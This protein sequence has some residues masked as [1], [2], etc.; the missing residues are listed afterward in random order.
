VRALLEDHLRSS[1]A[2]DPGTRLGFLFSFVRA[3][4]QMAAIAATEYVLAQI[5]AED[6]QAV[7]AA[8]KILH[9]LDGDMVGILDTLLP[10]IRSEQWPGCC[11]PWFEKTEAGV[12]SRRASAWVTVRTEMA[13]GNMSREFVEKQLPVLDVLATD[14]LAGLADLLPKAGPKDLAVLAIPGGSLDLQCV[15]ADSGKP[16]LLR[17]IRSSGG[18]WQARF[19]LVDPVTAREGTRQLDAD[20]WILAAASR[21]SQEFVSH[22]VQKPDGNLWKPAVRLPGKQTSAFQGRTEELAALRDW[23]NDVED[24]KV[25]LVYGDG[26][27]GKTTLALEFLNDL[28]DEPA[29]ITW[30]PDVITF[31][32]AKQTR[33]SPEGLV[34]LK[35]VEPAIL[36]G[37]RTLAK[38]LETR[39]DKSW[40]QDDAAAVVSR[41]ITLFTGAGIRRDQILIVVDNTE[42]LTRNSGDER[43]LAQVIGK[44][45][46]LGR[47]LLTSRRRE[48]IEARPVEISMMDEETGCRLLRALAQQAS[49]PCISSAGD[50]KLKQISR[51]LSGRPL[52]LEVFARHATKPGASLE[53]SLDLVLK[54]AED[55]LGDFLYA[56]A[57][58]RLPEE[59]RTVFFALEALGGHADNQTVAWI[60]TEA[61][62]PQS[63]WI[64]K[65][66]QETRFG[67]MQSY[68]ASFDLQLELGTRK[69]LAGKLAAVPTDQKAR[70]RAIA[71]KVTRR[72]RQLLAAATAQVEDRI[73]Q[74]FRSAPA[75]AA[76]LAAKA[77]NVED[78]LLWHEEAVKVDPQ[79]AA[80]WERYAWFVRTKTGNEAL[81]MTCAQKACELA[82]DDPE[83]NYTAG[84]IAAGQGN[85]EQ[86]DRYLE[87]AREHG[88]A[89]HMCHLQRARA[90]IQRA[91]Q[92]HAI[93]APEVAEA[94]ALLAQAHEGGGKDTRAYNVAREKEYQRMSWRLGRVTALRKGR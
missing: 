56:D 91:E 3:E 39:L 54:A 21:N 30:F 84:W 1:R 17:D 25:C 77:G 86:A 14:L 60:C 90:R 75:K 63:I 22:Q 79:N 12:L 52:L 50:A 45:S 62:V 92:R 82:P 61:E 18:R 93:S 13:H 65:A 4:L 11:K 36:E 10:L 34:Y 78:A 43:Q 9:P 44:L 8:K 46:R 73:V 31:Y 87:R 81:A 69:F 67:S 6:E 2:L 40:F 51:K 48:A 23:Y 33:W 71:D 16:V 57:W 32:S 38:L 66:F 85:P 94:R 74:A 47:V 29:G 64:D 49:A 42:T 35:G 88:K 28:L 20:L 72:Q 41:A 83:A 80:L 26:G 15:F 68:G 19:H 53:R 24:S 55:E 58:E 59:H 89:A 37:V 27:V 70:V 7:D 76:W 5:D